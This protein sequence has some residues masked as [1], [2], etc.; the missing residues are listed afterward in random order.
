MPEVNR[1]QEDIACEIVLAWLPHGATLLG[2]GLPSGDPKSYE[3]VGR[4]IGAVFK[5]V[6]KAVEDASQGRRR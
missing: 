2:K 5:E 1:T 4:R 3:E 6:L